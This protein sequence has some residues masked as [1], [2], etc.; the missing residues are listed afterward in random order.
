MQKTLLII[1]LGL[2]LTCHAQT[3]TTLTGSTE[4]YDV[5]AAPI[6]TSKFTKPFGVVVDQNDN[7]FISELNGHRIK[8]IS[9]DLQYVYTRSGS[10]GQLN[11]DAGYSNSAGG[12]GK[13]NAPAGLALAADN[14]LVVA[15]RENNSIR[16][17]SK[18]VNQSNPQTPAFIAGGTSQS[19]VGYVDGAATD[20][21]FNY[22]TDVAAASNGDIYVCDSYNHCIRKILGSTKAVSTFA[23]NAA[24]AP[25]DFADGQGS[26]AHFYVPSGI[27]WDK[28]G[29]L[30]VADK[31]NFRIR[32]INVATAPAGKVTTVAGNN[33]DDVIDGSIATASFKSPIDVICDKNGVIY[34]L[35]ASNSGSVIRKIAGGQVNSIAGDP[36]LSGDTD[37]KGKAATFDEPQQIAFNKAQTKIYITD[38]EN[39]RIRMLDPAGTIGILAN[40][41]LA[42]INMYPNPVMDN[43]VLNI[44]SEVSFGLKTVEVTDLSGRV[45][46]KENNVGGATIFQANI[47]NLGSGLYM[48]NLYGADNAKVTRQFIVR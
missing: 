31:N 39:H 37:G 42:S 11:G 30:L 17:L 47:N 10:P 5:N 28:N 45:L 1:A 36:D 7:I 21:R 6:A 38:R 41:S 44:Q 34:V 8:M 20:A 27:C 43:G 14:S 26:A 33:T 23:G 48:V 32:R 35:E 29:D 19:D 46:T 3:V 12:A 4:G 24:I 9:G 25:P 13:W 2:V 22:P 16:S 18:Y 40:Y 15:D